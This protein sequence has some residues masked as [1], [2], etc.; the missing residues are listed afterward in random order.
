MVLL[1]MSDEGTEMPKRTCPVH[2]FI[3]EEEHLGYAC[4]FCSTPLVLPLP[5]KASKAAK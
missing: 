5:R 2:L 3:K 4:F 1:A